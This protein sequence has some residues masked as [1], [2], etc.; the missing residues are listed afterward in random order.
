MPTKNQI[1]R[2]PAL[3]FFLLSV[4]L[5]LTNAWVFL[6]WELARSLVAGPHRVEEARLRFQ[7]FGKLLI[8]SIE[9]RYGAISAIPTHRSPQVVI[10]YLIFL[11]RLSI[12]RKA[13]FFSLRGG[14]CRLLERYGGG[15]I[16]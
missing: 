9:N 6:R 10:Y 1:H 12:Q 7:R 15:W 5:I 14:Y 2:N 4:G 8:L 13:C 3:R 16:P 11:F